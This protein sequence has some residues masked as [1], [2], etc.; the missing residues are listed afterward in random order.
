MQSP[1]YL[2]FEP[3]STIFFEYIPK[4][5]LTSSIR[6]TNTGSDRIAFK[7]RTNVPFSYLVKPR[8]GVINPNTFMD[9]H[10]TREPTDLTSQAPILNDKFLLD[11]CRILENLEMKMIKSI[12][13]T[14]PSHLIQSNKFSVAFHQEDY[15]FETKDTSVAGNSP[16]SQRNYQRGR[17]LSAIS[18]E[19]GDSFSSLLEASLSPSHS[20]EKVPKSKSLADIK[21]ESLLE[22]VGMIE[23]SSSE[24][25]VDLR[26]MPPPPNNKVQ[27]DPKSDRRLKEYLETIKK[28]L[29]ESL[30]KEQVK[31]VVNREVKG[32]GYFIVIVGIIIAMLLFKMA[33]LW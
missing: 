1:Q 17:F 29:N 28:N 3:E 2:H 22:K 12:F 11:A 8:I 32:R 26:C 30:Q 31:V 10:I 16:T 21:S 20:E 25:N 18:R 13:N 9:I 6:L 14:T 24:T 5:Y 7:V 19:E 27:A 15:N 4:R 33:Y 23:K